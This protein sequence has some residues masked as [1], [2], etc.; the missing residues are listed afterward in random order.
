MRTSAVVSTSF[1]WVNPSP[2]SFLFPVVVFPA[3]VGPYLLV[4]TVALLKPISCVHALMFIFPIE[5][6][7]HASLEYSKL[8]LCVIILK[9]ALMPVLLHIHVSP[10][11]VPLT[12]VVPMPCL[13]SCNQAEDIIFLCS[14]W[15]W[16][17]LSE[18]DSRTGNV[19]VT[20]GASSSFHLYHWKSY[21]TDFD[22]FIYLCAVCFELRDMREPWCA[23]ILWGDL[24]CL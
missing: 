1:C 11:V 23:R 4:L 7:R 5:M 9:W 12:V 19:S 15:W 16:S 18:A 20:H 3:Q 10:V 6:W 22:W 14:C 13:Q 24:F 8:V 2:A 17:F 21:S